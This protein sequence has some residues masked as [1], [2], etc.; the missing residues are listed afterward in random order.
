[1][2][3]LNPKRGEEILI[4]HCLT[5]TV[6]EINR[7]CVKFGIDDVRLGNVGGELSQPLA[8][9]CRNRSCYFWF[10][11]HG[12]CIL[13]VTCA[14]GK[15]ISLAGTSRVAVLDVAAESATLAFTGL[16]RIGAS[17]SNARHN[18]RRK[19]TMAPA[20]RPRP[21]HRFKS[22]ANRLQPQYASPSRIW[23]WA[24]F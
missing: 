4:S 13:V 5:L 2:T 12:R 18:D 24:S 7:H 14:K 22:G 23:R 9:I 19:E 11:I 16:P 6:L 1:M 3:I 8:E 20:A 10:P 21:T 17:M 15:E